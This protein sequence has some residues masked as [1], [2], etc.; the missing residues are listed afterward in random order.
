MEEKLALN[1]AANDYNKDGL[2]TAADITYDM[3]N[4]YDTDSKFVSLTYTPKI[5]DWGG[6]EDVSG[7]PSASLSV[8]LLTLCLSVYRPVDTL[9]LCLSIGL[10]TLCLSVCLSAC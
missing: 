7:W 2:V 6:V 5:G 4:N 8:G 1:A 9:P 3:T 10:L